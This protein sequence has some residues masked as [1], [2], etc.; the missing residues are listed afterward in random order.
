MN[1]NAMLDFSDTAVKKFVIVR[2]RMDAIQL[3]ENAVAEMAGKV[4]DALRH[5]KKAAGDQIV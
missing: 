4:T 1:T 3:L 5:V 2:T